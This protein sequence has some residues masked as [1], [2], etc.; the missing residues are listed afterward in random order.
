[1]HGKDVLQWALRSLGVPSKREATFEANLVLKDTEI[2]SAERAVLGR[3]AEGRLDVLSNTLIG[4][5]QRLEVL[6]KKGCIVL[7]PDFNHLGLNHDFLII[8]DTKAVGAAVLAH[9]LEATVFE[10]SERSYAIVSAPHVWGKELLIVAVAAGLGVYPI[11]RVDSSRGFL[12]CE[13]V[14]PGNHEGLMWSDG[15]S[16]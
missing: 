14:F 15:R 4:S 12:R 13:D 6:T 7:L 1:M 8:G 3:L 5:P 2:K 11:A 16:S 9:A 10:V